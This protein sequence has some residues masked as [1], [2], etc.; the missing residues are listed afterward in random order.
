VG[1][2][3]AGILHPYLFARRQQHADR[4]IDRMLRSRGDDDLLGI[5]AH[6]SRRLK[7]VGDSAAQLRRA[8]RIGIAEMFGT[9]RAHR[10]MR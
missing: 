5:A 8:A 4:E 2:E 9:Q 1:E 10:A 3:V 6:P 7:I